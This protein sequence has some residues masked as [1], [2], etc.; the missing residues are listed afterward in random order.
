MPE[1]MKGYHRGPASFSMIVNGLNT[2]LSQRKAM[3]RS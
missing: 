3:I 1:D 2:I